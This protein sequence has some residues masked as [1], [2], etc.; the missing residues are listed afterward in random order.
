MLSRNRRW[1]MWCWSWRCRHRRSLQPRTGDW[2]LRAGV[3]QLNPDKN[4]LPDTFGGNVVFDKSEAFTLD[5]EYMFTEHLGADL[6]VPTYFSNDIQL[7][8]TPLGN[9]ARI[10]ETDVFTPILGLNWHFNPGGPIRPYLGVG[11]N[12]T[13]FS[14]EEISNRAVGLPAN[15]R[16]DIDQAWGPAGRIGVDIGTDEHWFLNLDVRYVDLDTDVEARVPSGISTTTVPVGEANIDPWLY[17]ICSRVP[18]RSR[19]TAA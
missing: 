7:K 14:G 5:A 3:H 2:L 17:G 16:L 6:F 12:W 18:L 1:M 13:D 19:E 8:N 9:S 4:N 10:G 11:V 15:S